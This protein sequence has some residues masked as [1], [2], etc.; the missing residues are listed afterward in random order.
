MPIA[1]Q[2]APLMRAPARHARQEPATAD[3]REKADA[4]F[5]HGVDG[6]LGRDAEARRI[7]YADASAHDYAVDE[8]DHGL[9]ICE[10]Q[11]VQPI[12]GVEEA[13][14]VRTVAFRAVGDHGDVAACA[15]AA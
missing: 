11:M 13:L 15:E 6:S 9:F 4:C 1:A 12:F 7:G 2:S 3:V 10:Q 5:G 14:R 8:G